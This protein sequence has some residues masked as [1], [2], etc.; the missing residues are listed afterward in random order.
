MSARYGLLGGTFDPVHA[1]HLVLA[2]EALRQLDLAGVWFLPAG[3]PWMKRDAPLTPKEH[4]RAM[5]EL[6]V[7]SDERFHLSTAELDRPGET[8]TVDTL[9][10]MR[11]GDA[12]DD[13][14]WFIVG[15]DTLASMHRWK[16]P[17]R[18]LELARIAVAMRPGHELLDL[19]AL[20]AVAPDARGRVTTVRMPLM[21]VSGTDV[22]RRAAA[23]ESLEGLVPDA[24][25]AY[26]ARH[27]LYGAMRMKPT[28][29][30]GRRT[31][32]RG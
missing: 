29:N 9:E 19:G 2:D 3:E 30:A 16:D 24:V 1:A 27:D 31:R 26:I 28:T 25:A 7:A 15:A 5:V 13:E 8:Y 17:A 11:A 20:E 12:A 23:G 32:G 4:R 10:A 6:A 18:L 22:R 21:G 14:V